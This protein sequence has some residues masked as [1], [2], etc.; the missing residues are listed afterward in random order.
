MNYW[1]AA[2][3]NLIGVLRAAVRHDLANCPRRAR[4][5]AKVQYGARGWVC[6]HNT[7]GW[8]GTAPVDCRCSG[9]WPTGGAWLCKSLWD[10]YRVH[11]RQ[12]RAGGATIPIMKGAAQF[13]LDTLVE[14]PTHHWLVTCPSVSPENAHHPARIDL[15]RADHGHADPARPVR[16]LRR[17]VRDPGHRRRFPRAGAGGARAACPDAD[18]PAGPVAGVAGRLGRLAA[19]P[20][21]RHVSHLYGLYPSNQI[22][23]RGTPELF[24]AARKSLE[25]RG[26]EAT[27]WS[28]AWKINLWARL[29]D[30]DHAYKLLQMLL[31][32]GAD[33]PQPVRPAPAVPD[34][35]QLRRRRPA[36]ARCC[37]KATPAN[38]TCCPPCRPP[39]PTGSVTG[40]RA[41]GGFDCRPRLAGGQTY[42]SRP[43]RG[44]CGHLW[45]R[46]GRPVDHRRREVCPP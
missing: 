46:H 25:M 5:T 20:H 13:F 42:P 27:G 7:D 22:T 26:D 11:R 28:L 14:E 12:R 34:R 24:A 15:R 39:G 31:T 1:P 2:P 17:G 23:R 18:R 35:R 44:S 45:P 40:L 6:H 43:A 32:P 9:M 19:G 33:G 16:R 41:R 30:G 37:C 21:H 4:D 29:E 10:H 36:S 8:R 3:A 38:C